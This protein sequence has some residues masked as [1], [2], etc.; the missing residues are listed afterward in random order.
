[1]LSRLRVSGYRSIREL[2]MPLAAV[3][4]VLGANGSGKSNLYRSLAL[5]WSAANGSLASSLAA[6]GGIASALWAGHRHKKEAPRISLAIDIDDLSYELVLGRV[7]VSS[8]FGMTYATSGDSFQQFFADDPD[9]K[10]ETLSVDYRGKQISL[11]D[12]TSSNISARNMDGRPIE[13]PLVVSSSESVLTGLREP[14]L[15]P[16]LAKL[17]S[18]ILSWRFYHHFRTDF[19]SPLREP[20][21]STFSPVLRDDGSNLYAALATIAAIEGPDLVREAV[22]DA[23]PGTRLDFSFSEGLIEIELQQPGLERP[24]NAAELS[25]GTLQYLALLAALLTPRPPG[26]LVLNEPET[27]V[28]SSLYGAMGRLIVQAAKRTQVFVTTHCDE[29]AR[30]IAAA[31]QIKPILL[32]KNEGAT[33]IVAGGAGGGGGA[34]DGRNINQLAKLDSYSN[35]AYDFASESDLCW[36]S[37]LGASFHLVRI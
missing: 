13:Y 15:F 17:R 23:F 4:V 30:Q 31:C 21:I 35:F 29:L 12:R 28:H 1:M 36:Q 14:H 7:P 19:N 37:G 34:G 10:S 20:Q 18:D 11:L 26:L 25:D 22:D 6:E 2:A 8:L 24:L 33:N 27:S 3:N 16:D 32:E 5:I 9:I